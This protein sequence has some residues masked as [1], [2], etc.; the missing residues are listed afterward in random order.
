MKNE[1]VKTNPEIIRMS[2]GQ[3][4]SITDPELQNELANII[5]N[6]ENRGAMI[7][8][9]GSIVNT[10]F[11]VGF[12][13]KSDFIPKGHWRCQLGNLHENGQKCEDKEGC[14]LHNHARYQEIMRL[15]RKHIRLGQC[16]EP[17]ERIGVETLDY[18]DCKY[19]HALVLEMKEIERQAENVGRKYNY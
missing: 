19:T 12:Y 5:L 6:P 14:F 13:K 11:L 7:R 9:N 8:V 1:I 17:P 3:E 2:D 18:H 15:L 16:P 10:S 4:F